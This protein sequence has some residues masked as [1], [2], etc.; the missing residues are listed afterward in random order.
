MGTSIVEGL[1]AWG[2]REHAALLDALLPPLCWLCRVERCVDG[3]GCAQHALADTGFEPDEARC[4]ACLER[5]PEG[6]PA[7]ADVRCAECRRGGR[8]YRRLLAHGAYHAGEGASPARLREWI[9]AFKHGRRADLARPLGACLVRVLRD[10]GRPEERTCLVP[11]PLHPLRRL[12]RGHD[13]AAGLARAV[14]EALGIAVERRLVRTRWT[15]P[16]G[17]A[18]ARSRSANVRGA[19]RA[20]GEGLAGRAVTLVDDVV[21]SGATVAEAAAVLR[22]AGAA[23]VSVLALAK[24]D[25]RA[26]GGGRLPPP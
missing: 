17:S 8:G 7:G 25:R 21:T 13:Q 26:D 6:V 5:L 10:Q 22:A 19:F 11:I 16:Q 9:L 18:A 20:R 14:G 15:P 4:A 24:V 3:L 2:R 12:E 1:A 23:R